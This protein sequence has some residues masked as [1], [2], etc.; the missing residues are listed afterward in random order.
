[1]E[2][3]NAEPLVNT[4]EETE[5][6]TEETPTSPVEEVAP[7]EGTPTTPAEEATLGEESPTTPV[8]TP[9]VE[10][11]PP[12]E[13]P[14]TPEITETPTTPSL[15]DV[16]P[17]TI[18][19]LPNPVNLDEAVAENATVRDMVSNFSIC[20]DAELTVIIGRNRDANAVN[21]LLN[22]LDPAT[23]ERYKHYIL[24]RTDE[25]RRADPTLAVMREAYTI[26][27][28]ARLELYKQRLAE[29]RA[30]PETPV[31]GEAPTAG[32]ETLGDSAEP[33]RSR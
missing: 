16:D 17:L 30:A 9:P 18:E 12:V 4:R 19:G 33:G 21:N 14:T 26:N 13:S 29:M 3:N 23:Y 11:A 5:V 15:D 27:A 6:P 8:E 31:G 20:S 28:R 32:D 1:M 10:E 2:R 25:E 7:V 22:Y 24:E